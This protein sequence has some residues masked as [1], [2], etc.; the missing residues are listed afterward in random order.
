MENKA[1]IINKYESIERCIN[2][3]NEEYNRQM[4]LENE[5]KLKNSKEREKEKDKD[6]DK[7]KDDV[8]MFKSCLVEVL[9]YVNILHKEDFNNLDFKESIY[10]INNQILKASKMPTR[11]E[12]TDYVKALSPCCTDLD[13]LVNGIVYAIQISN[14][15]HMRGWY[16]K[17][18]I[19]R[20]KYSWTH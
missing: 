9:A 14:K 10:S 7:D 5:A 18:Y 2:R 8:T 17:N 11:Q 19:V 4:S 12:I 20:K 13:T 3:I 16:G 1:V 15:K 6:I